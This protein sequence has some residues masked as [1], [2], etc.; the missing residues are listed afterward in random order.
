MSSKMLVA[1]YVM[2]QTCFPGTCS[3]M[4]EVRIKS[5]NLHIYIYM[6]ILMTS[7]RGKTAIFLRENQENR[8]NSN[9]P[10]SNF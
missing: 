5:I 9:G 6:K 4:G 2:G 3:S 10:G 8:P 7:P 1:C